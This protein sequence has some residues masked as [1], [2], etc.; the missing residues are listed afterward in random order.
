MTESVHMQQVSSEHDRHSLH[1]QWGAPSCH[2]S[3]PHHHH[4][5]HHLIVIILLITKRTLT[6]GRSAGFG[7]QRLAQ[8]GSSGRESCQQLAMASPNHYSCLD[9]CQLVPLHT[10][11]LARL[12]TPGH[13]HIN[14]IKHSGMT[15]TQTR[16]FM[17]LAKT[18]NT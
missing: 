15:K 10:A 18:L 3:V 2:H 12:H 4:H 6:G 14:N 13:C 1:R 8:S 11:S 7:G 5:H 17:K 16:V 9:S